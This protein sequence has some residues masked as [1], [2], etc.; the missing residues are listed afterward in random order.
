[1]TYKILDKKTKKYIATGVK[2]KNLALEFLSDVL[3]KQAEKRYS[4]MEE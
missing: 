4:I 3:V 2:N 1:M